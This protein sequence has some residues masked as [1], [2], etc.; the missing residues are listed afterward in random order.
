MIVSLGVIRD[1]RGRLCRRFTRA[2]WAGILQR[3]KRRG[4]HQD[5]ANS[6]PK[7]YAKFTHI[8]FL[9]REVSPS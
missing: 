1:R 4:P 6:N 2:R 8:P 3:K 7:S 9:P 5:R